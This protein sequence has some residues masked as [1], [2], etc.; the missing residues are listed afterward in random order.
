M[1]TSELL[2]Q[3]DT[4]L[5]AVVDKARQSLVEISNGRRGQGAGTIWHSDGLI[6]TNAHVVHG[7]TPIVT[8]PDGPWCQRRCW[9]TMQ[10]SMWPRSKVDATGLPTVELGEFRASCAPANGYWPWGIRGASRAGY[11]RRRDR[12]RAR[13]GRSCR[14]PG[15]GERLRSPPTMPAASGWS[16]AFTTCAP[17]TPVA[18]W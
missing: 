14:S 2:Q 17:A 6:V 7:R 11:S 13:T 1:E 9:R 3:I 12:L 18:P 5:S 10:T 4:D 16:P 15:R 8:L